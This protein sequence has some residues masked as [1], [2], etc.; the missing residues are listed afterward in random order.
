MRLNHAARA[1]A[2]AA[3][4][5]HTLLDHQMSTRVDL[6]HRSWVVTYVAWAR[7]LA[8]AG[9]TGPGE[10]GPAGPAAGTGTQDTAGM[11][12]GTGTGTG[13]GRR[14]ACSGSPGGRA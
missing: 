9:S 10:D 7:S 5:S 2:R 8:A 3:A 13:S 12:T 14:A 1:A 6:S 11:G 4:P